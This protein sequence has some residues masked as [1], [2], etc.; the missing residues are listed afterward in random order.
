MTV[1]GKKGPK[2]RTFYLVDDKLVRAKKYIPL[3]NMVLE[4]I[5]SNGFRLTR[6]S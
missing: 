6:N 3:G 5:K 2:E 4:K 1:I